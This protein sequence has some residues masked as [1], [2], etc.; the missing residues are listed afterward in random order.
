[1]PGIGPVFELNGTDAARE[2]IR[3]TMRI[4]FDYLVNDEVLRNQS[5]NACEVCKLRAE[6][7]KGHY[8]HFTLFARIC[9]QLGKFSEAKANYEIAVGTCKED[10]NWDKN[11]PP[12]IPTITEIISGIEEEKATL[13]K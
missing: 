7:N 11:K 3:G 2:N 6:Y 4:G 8:D 5:Q 10:L 12:K 13:N 9:R 1:M